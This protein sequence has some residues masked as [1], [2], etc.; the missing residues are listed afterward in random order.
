ML[1][2]LGFRP[3]PNTRPWTEK[4]DEYLR[5]NYGKIKRKVLAEALG[6][7]INA[8]QTRAKH[9]NLTDDR[10]GK[11]EDWTKEELQKLKRWHGKKSRKEMAELLERTEGA[12]GTKITSLNLGQPGLWTEEEDEYIRRHYQTKSRREIAEALNRT[13]S[14]VGKHAIKLGLTNKNAPNKKL[15]T[16]EEDA[17]LEKY[18]GVKSYAEIAKMIGRSVYSVE[19]RSRK[20]KSKEK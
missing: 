18:Y 16:P 4:D 17:L 11:I 5:K 3:R 10:R 14:S 1:T 9:F 13:I 8:I 12:I 6:R 2:R 7:T 19:T 15:W 20:F